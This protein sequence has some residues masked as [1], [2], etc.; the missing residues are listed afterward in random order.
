MIFRHV[1]NYLVFLYPWRAFPRSANADRTTS[2]DLRT[3][4]ARR[5]ARLR[6]LH[7][8]LPELRL[9]A[10]PRL[11]VNQIERNLDAGTNGASKFPLPISANSGYVGDWR[12]LRERWLWGLWSVSSGYDSGRHPGTVHRL[13]GQPR[14]SIGCPS[15]PQDGS[16][17]GIV[18]QP[19]EQ[20]RARIDIA[21]IGTVTIAPGSRVSLTATGK[22]QHRLALEKGELEAHVKAP[23]RLFIVDTQAGKAVDLGCAYRLTT[24]PDGVTTLNVTAGQVALKDCWT[25]FRCPGRRFLRSR[26]AEQV[27]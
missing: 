6:T 10:A 12:W 16:M 7:T 23:P 14:V 20:S 13:S 19:M 22:A 17:W 27:W 11:V 8:V 3:V 1:G 26:G 9:H 18:L 5:E 21:D 24:S 2:S 4:P 15:A 25:V